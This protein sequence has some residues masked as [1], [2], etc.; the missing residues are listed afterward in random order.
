MPEQW[1]VNHVCQQV[2]ARRPTEELQMN[3]EIPVGWEP[4]DVVLNCRNGEA[5][6]LRYV[7]RDR[8]VL[9]IEA[10]PLRG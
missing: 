2:L 3:D 8:N 10:A 5:R 1:L 4:G 6:E 9:G 7:D